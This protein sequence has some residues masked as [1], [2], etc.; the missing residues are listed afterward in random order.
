MHVARY[1][2]RTPG[3]IRPVTLALDFDAGL[4]RV[5]DDRRSDELI[6]AAG[7]VAASLPARSIV[8][9]VDIARASVDVVLAGS[10]V[11]TT[12]SP[13]V[14]RAVDSIV[15]W[16]PSVWHADW[17]ALVRS[18]GPSIVDAVESTLRAVFPVCLGAN[19]TPP[20]PAS[21]RRAAVRGPDVN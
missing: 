14:T 10:E 2:I 13:E 16:A 6:D 7:G 17:S 18:S 4:W 12:T 1:L 19:G 5:R 3:A 20:D 8:Q 11:A 15:H 21:Y 9:D